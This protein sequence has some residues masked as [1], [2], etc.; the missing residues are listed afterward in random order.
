MEDELRELI[1]LM[2]E[3]AIRTDEQ[4]KRL[5]AAVRFQNLVCA[6]VVAVVVLISFSFAFSTPY[7]EQ[8]QQNE[9]GQIQRQGGTVE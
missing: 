4:N 7:P 6:V 2:K 3:C 8:L 1:A 9:S 5:I